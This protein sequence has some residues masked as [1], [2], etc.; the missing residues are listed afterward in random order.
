MIFWTRWIIWLVSIS[1]SQQT[2]ENTSQSHS[3]E[4]LIPNN[5]PIYENQEADPQNA[6]YTLENLLM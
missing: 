4:E 5:I 6:W 1:D 3:D 2:T